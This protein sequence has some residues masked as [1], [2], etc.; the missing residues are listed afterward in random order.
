MSSDPKLIQG[1]MAIKQSI[2][3]SA[4]PGLSVNTHPNA[5]FLNVAGAI[6][7]Y[8]AADAAYRRFC[9]FEQAVKARFE[10]EVAAAA[11]R[12]NDGGGAAITMNV[13]GAGGAG[14][15]GGNVEIISLPPDSAKA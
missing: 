9:E 5:L 11:K 10:A 6:D 13:T 7:L 3:R 1:A 8:A 15:G 2:E 4:S 14:G 12:S